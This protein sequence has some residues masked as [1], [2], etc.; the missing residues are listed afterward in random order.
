MRL[1]AVP[2]A[3]SWATPPR[4]GCLVLSPRAASG[5]LPGPLFSH[6]LPGPP[7]SSRDQL[8][9]GT[10]NAHWAAAMLLRSRDAAGTSAFRRPRVPPPRPRP[11]ALSA[12]HWPRS[13]GLRPLL[14]RGWVLSC[15]CSESGEQV[16][17][18]SDLLS[19]Y[20]RAGFWK[21]NLQR[22]PNSV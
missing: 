18:A 15:V 21:R 22:E 12:A 13:P 19:V 2:G 20:C 1:V 8:P 3:R 10:G 11:R 17:G 9:P 7:H 4:A 16:V 5:I 6:A 14:V